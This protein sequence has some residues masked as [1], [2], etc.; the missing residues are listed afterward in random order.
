MIAPI[1]S[2]GVYG[3]LLH[4]V[5]SLSTSQFIPGSLLHTGVLR[6]FAGISL[7]CTIYEISGFLS[8][9]YSSD[10]VKTY[11]AFTIIEVLGYAVAFLLMRTSDLFRPDFVFL[12][13]IIIAVSISFSNLSYTSHIFKKPHLWIGN[14]SMAMYLTNY[15]ARELAIMLL[16]EELNRSRLVPYFF[17][18]IAF[19]I[20][21]M[22]ISYIISLTLKNKKAVLP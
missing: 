21:I 4:N 15:P 13:L 1:I 20:L 16:P 22:L 14:L 10:S 12:V 8:R 6:A 11:V 2:I 7:G 5:E 9:K 19:A 18:N 17:I 3:Y